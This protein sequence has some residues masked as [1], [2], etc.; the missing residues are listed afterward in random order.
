MKTSALL[1]AL[2]YSLIVAPL[3]L[4]A[5]QGGAQTYPVKPVR[6]VV[7]FAPG[8]GTDAHTRTV[9]QIAPAGTPRPIMRQLN[10]EIN[11]ILRLPDIQQRLFSDGTAFGENTPEWMAAFVG[12]EIEKWTKVAK[13]SG[14]R[15]E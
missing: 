5:H 12:R 2:R 8:G 1:Q 9:G 11:T 13:A 3:L 7:P 4:V 6:V 10:R 15:A 14:T